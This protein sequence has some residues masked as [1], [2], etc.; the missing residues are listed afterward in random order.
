MG[1]AEGDVDG[2]LAQ[3]VCDREGG[4]PHVDEQTH[5]GV[6]QVV[7][8]DPL[9]AGRSASPLHLVREVV[10]GYFE[11]A[12]PVANVLA[13]VQVLSDLLV[14]ELGYLDGAHGFR[15]LRVGYQ[16]L[17]VEP[18]VGR[19]YPHLHADEVEGL[20]DEGEE[21]P[22]AD[23]GPVED[24]EHDE[25]SRLLHHSLGELE[26]LFL[27]PET[28]LPGFPRAY[29]HG[30]DRGV[31]VQPV[32]PRCM[33]EDG[34][35]LVVDGPEV[36]GRVRLSVRATA[37]N[38]LVLPLDDVYAADVLHPHLTEVGLYL[39]VYHVL[40]RRPGRLA[41]PR[42]LSSSYILRKS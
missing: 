8:S 41:Q 27:R 19:R 23:P 35:E 2:L 7:D 4:E 28:H 5:V 25:G 39:G 17:S 18:L 40:L 6:A 20:G 13:A 16:V 1:V 14:E 15:R 33:V 36:G 34:V 3:S 12:L 26:V 37:V 38:Q 10:L 42:S 24:L 9:H 29:L 31:W 32:V 30:L 21:L 22:D 11:H